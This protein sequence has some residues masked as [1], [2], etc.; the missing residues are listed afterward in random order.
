MCSVIFF[1]PNGNHQL[2]S[3]Y[4]GVL[5]MRNAQQLFQL[6][7]SNNNTRQFLHL[8]C[9]NPSAMIEEVQNLSNLLLINICKIHS[10]PENNPLFHP[11]MR[12]IPLDRKNG[13]IYESYLELFVWNKE[14]GCN[15]Q[16]CE[17]LR[18]LRLIGEQPYPTI[19]IS[20]EAND[21][22]VDTTSNEC[23]LSTETQ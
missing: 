5:F 11:N 6:I 8:C 14:N 23:N 13:Y 17:N 18:Q 16:A 1:D 15:D 4:S 22:N 12:D 19:Q 3:T 20:N 9:S 7:S 2:S 21:L 10:G